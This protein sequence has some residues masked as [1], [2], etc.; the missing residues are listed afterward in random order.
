MH[1]CLFLIHPQDRHEKAT[2]ALMSNPDAT[3]SLF[4]VVVPEWRNHSALAL[5]LVSNQTHAETLNSL[6]FQKLPLRKYE[7]VHALLSDMGLQV[8]NPPSPVQTWAQ[9]GQV[10]PGRIGGGGDE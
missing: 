1:A 3:E 7:T 2:L 9:P 4:R 6:A 10:D 8:P 5:Q